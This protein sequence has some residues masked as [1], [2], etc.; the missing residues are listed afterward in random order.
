MV[1][2]NS[3]ND[4]KESKES[5]KEEGKEDGDSCWTFDLLVRCRR[6]WV[7]K[8][9][10]G[11]NKSSK[12]RRLVVLPGKLLKR[13]RNNLVVFY[14]FYLLESRLLISFWFISLLGVYPKLVYW[15]GKAALFI[16]CGTLSIRGEFS[17]YC[18]FCPNLF[19]ILPLE[20]IFKANASSGLPIVRWPIG[21]ISGFCG[22]VG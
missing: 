20:I 5:G 6:I 17:G 21:F 9:F 3:N 16:C 4:T 10:K 18:F 2:V 15:D 12:R 14:E 8:R 7:K 1:N 13:R 19:S 11:E 22:L